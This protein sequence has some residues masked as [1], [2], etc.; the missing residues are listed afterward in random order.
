MR[1]FR[2]ALLG[3]GL[4]LIAGPGRAAP[5]GAEAPAMAAAPT[6]PEAATA[7]AAR[8]N[9]AIDAW[10]LELAAAWL[11]LLVGFDLV[12]AVVCLALFRFVVEA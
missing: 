4:L 5:P 8:F 7:A 11:R 1:G 3:A 9:A 2:R 10:D 12:Y 6:T